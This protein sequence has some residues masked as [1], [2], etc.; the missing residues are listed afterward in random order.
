MHIYATI[1]PFG[2]WFGVWKY[3]QSIYPEIWRV[4]KQQNNDNILLQIGSLLT[5]TLDQFHWLHSVTAPYYKYNYIAVG[6]ST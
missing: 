3:I 2:I 4:M 5:I 6:K 1:N